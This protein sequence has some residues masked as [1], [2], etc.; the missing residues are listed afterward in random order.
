MILARYGQKVT[1]CSGE[2]QRCTIRAFLQPVL[3]RGEEQVVP[4]PLGVRWEGR[5]LYLGPVHAALTAEVSRIE[6][7]GRCYVVQTACL[8]GESHWWAILRP[9]EGG[10]L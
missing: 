5:Y 4:S 7:E 2:G 8:V 1:V 6:Y 3:D 9:G 10:T